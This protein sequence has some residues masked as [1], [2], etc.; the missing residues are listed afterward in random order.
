MY[1]HATDSQNV[2]KLRMSQSKPGAQYNGEDLIFAQREN[3]RENENC[4]AAVK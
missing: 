3:S 4:K 2:S 1:V